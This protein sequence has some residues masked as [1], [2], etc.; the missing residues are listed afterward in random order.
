M[1]VLG[2]PAV[3]I[4]DLGGFP[5]GMSWASDDTIVFAS[6]ASNGLMRVPSVGGEPEVLT[7][8][9]PEQGETAHR[10]PEVLP[11]GKGVLF[12]AWSGSD[13]GSRIAVVSLETGEITYLVP[14]GSNPHY[15]PTEHIV[16]GVGG[17]LRAVGFDAERLALTSN[18]PVPVV[19]NVNTKSASGAANFSLAGNGSLVYVAGAGGAG[20]GAQRT[21]VWVDREGREEPLASPLAGYTRPRLSP[22]GTRVAVD[23]ADAEGQDVWIHDLSRDTRTRLTTDPAND[24]APL[25]TPDGQRVVFQSDREG[26]TGLFWKLADG[27][28]EAEHLMSGREG[29]TFLFPET[30]SADGK[31]LVYWEFNQGPDIGILLME[32]ERTSEPLLATEFVEAGP[33]ISP[34]GGWIAYF[35]DETGQ[36]QVSVQRFPDLGERVTVSTDGGREPVWSRDGREL[37]F[38]GPRGMMVVPVETEPTFRAGDPEVLFQQRYFDFLASRTYDV[39]PDGQRFLMI[40]EGPAT[41]DGSV[42]LAQIT[43]VLNWFEEL[44]RLVPVP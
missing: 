9:D 18:N 15:S 19:E 33:A 40:K 30:W 28:G 34:D 20:G 8:V 43:V 35:S 1:S 32:G 41:D 22:E 31:T 14:G 26:K 38:R 29:T 3:T 6:T 16:Y 24:F 39:F 12:T 25:W 21:L 44:K 17:T 10:W 37:F 2:G 11:N 36:A 42:P 4:C 23:V 5:F 27:T 7:T 13:D